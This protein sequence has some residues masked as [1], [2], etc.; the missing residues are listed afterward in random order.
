M[1]TRTVLGVVTVWTVVGLALAATAQAAVLTS[2]VVLPQGTDDIE[3]TIVNAS[4]QIRDVTI[5]VWRLNGSLVDSSA[6]SLEPGEETLLDA[7]D[8]SAYRYCRFIVEGGKTNFRAA[9]CIFQHLVGHRM[10]VTAE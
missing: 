4:T 2:P 9:A 1:K 8:Q 3:C 5:Q 10:C 7:A 6:K